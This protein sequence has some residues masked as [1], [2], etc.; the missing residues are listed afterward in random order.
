MDIKKLIEKIRQ[1]L[2]VLVF[3]KGIKD[4]EVIDKSHK[5]DKMILKYQSEDENKEEE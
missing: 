2:Y 3:K 5:L 1:E 4:K